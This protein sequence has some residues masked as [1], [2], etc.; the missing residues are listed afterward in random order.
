MINLIHL[1]WVFCVDND[2][3]DV[4]RGPRDKKYNRYRGKN[5]VCSL[6]PV[7]LPQGRL[8]SGSNSFVRD[9]DLPVDH[10]VADHHYDGGH[11]VLEEETAVHIH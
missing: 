10:G 5:I 8:L 1:K 3:E 2:I 11:Q 9:L 4:K 7:H 6:S